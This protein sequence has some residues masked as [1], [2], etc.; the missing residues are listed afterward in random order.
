MDDLDFPLPESV[1][2]GDAHMQ[3]LMITDDRAELI[4]FEGFCWGHPEWDLA[5]TATE[6]LTA[7]FWTTPQYHAFVDSYGFD[8]TSW[9]GFPVLRRAR[10]VSMTTWLMQNVHEAPKIHDEFEARIE[11][12]RT[13]R[14][15][16]PWRAF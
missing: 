7:G 4:D 13:G 9:S 6:Y 11:T 16:R 1:N 3:N 15:I 5:M 12:L 8:V 14:P 2:H 10:E